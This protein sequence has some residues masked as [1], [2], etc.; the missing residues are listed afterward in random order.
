MNVIR[1]YYEDGFRIVEPFCHGESTAGND[2]L[3]AFQIG[4]YSKSGNPRGWKL[5]EISKMT[6]LSILEDTFDGR[7]P[8]YNPNDTGMVRY[9]CRV[10]RQP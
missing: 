1:F 10:P 7:R 9:Y 5:Y 8:H 4:G 2:V 6:N 3:R